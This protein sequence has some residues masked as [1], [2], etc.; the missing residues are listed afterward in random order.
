MT[1]LTNRKAF[2]SVLSGIRKEQG[3]RSAHQFFK[4]I[5]GSKSLGLAYVSYWDME[6]GKKLPKSWR[7][8]TIMAAL[9][10]AQYSPK[11]QELV[12]AYFRALSGSD[13][14]LQY[15]SAPAAAA[16]ALPS[17]ELAEAAT[18][19]MLSQL[20]VNLTLEQWK[21][22]TRDMVTDICQTYLNETA[23]WV[24]VSELS[25]AT[26]FKPKAIT[27]AL[28]ALA[29]GGIVDLSGNKTRGKFVGKTIQ[30]LPM[31]PATAGIRAALRNNC[32]A[33]LADS[34]LIALKRITVRMTKA[35]LNIYRQ[36][37]ENAVKLAAVYG[38]VNE[39]R[40]DSAI[41][42]IDARIYQF[43]PRD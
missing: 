8:K 25:K 26:K 6:R 41:Y 36:H 32:N 2:G 3:F 31:T 43:L 35:N 40:Q 17:R 18:H 20:S 24:T 4:N 15:L 34:K 37:L 23:G 42:F 12:Q 14:L 5:G 7:L 21:L 33:W 22:C 1:N 16:P 19:K 27:K 11:A 28:K 10:V 38:G 9:G 13:E 30:L 39:N 29:A